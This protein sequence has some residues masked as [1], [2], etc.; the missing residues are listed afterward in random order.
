MPARGWRYP[1]H[2]T[3]VMLRYHL[4]RPMLHGNH[5]PDHAARGAG[6]GLAIAMTPTVGLQIAMVMTLWTWVKTRKPQ[7]NFNPVLAIAWTM[8]TNVATVP[9]IYFMFVVTGRLMMGHWDGLSGYDDYTAKIAASLNPDAGW[10]ESIWIQLYVL[11]D[12]FGLPLLIGCLPWA[13]ICGWGGYYFTHRFVT[14]YHAM[15]AHRRVS[16]Y[17]MMG[18]EGRSSL[19]TKDQS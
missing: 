4:I 14:K 10:L 18:E 3:R 15:R 6:V 8:I 7:W 17:V 11:F 5:P 12:T 9:P 13:I 1:I 16:R 19:S 2:W